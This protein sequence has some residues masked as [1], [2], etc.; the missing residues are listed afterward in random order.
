[1]EATTGKFS[2]KTASINTANA[3]RDE[4]LRAPDF[5]DA[6]KNPEITFSITKVSADKKNKNKFMVEGDLNMHGVTKKQTLSAEYVG[7][8]KD[9][10]GNTKAGFTFS[11]KLNRKDYGIVWNK[12]LDS[13]NL[14]LG[15]EVEL[16]INIEAAQAK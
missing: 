15:D 4:H 13:G 2:I 16:A 6:A 14:L 11:G 7:T 3:K 10:W 8:E 9:P 12:T 1:V 5:F